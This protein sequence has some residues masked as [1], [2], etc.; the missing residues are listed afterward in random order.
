MFIVVKE[1]FNSE[2][3]RQSRKLQVH[4][5][6][7]LFYSSHHLL[8]I[9]SNI[10]SPEIRSLFLGFSKLTGNKSSTHRRHSCGILKRIFIKHIR[11]TKRNFIKNNFILQQSSPIYTY[12][13]IY[14]CYY[15]FLYFIF[16]HLTFYKP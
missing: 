16:I 14:C 1:H 9:C 5:F 8:T 7:F 4:F 11:Q 15:Y 2:A 6:A 10:E 13:Y 3:L 12:I